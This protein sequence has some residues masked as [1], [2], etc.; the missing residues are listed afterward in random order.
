MNEYRALKGWLLAPHARPLRL[1]ACLPG[2]RLHPKV[3]GWVAAPDTPECRSALEELGYLRRAEE[4]YHWPGPQT[5]MAHQRTTVDFLMRHRRCLVLNDMGTGK[6]LSAIWAMHRLMLAGEIKRALVICPLSTIHFTWG[7]ALFRTLWPEG[8]RYEALTAPAASRLRKLKGSQQID[9]L[10]HGDQ[11]LKAIAKHSIGRYDLVVID[12]VSKYRNATKTWT[13]F[14]QWVS[15]PQ[16]EEMRVWGMTGT[17]TPQRPADS[18]VLSKLIRNKH[19]PKTWYKCRDMLEFKPYRD[20]FRWT[21]RHGWQ[22]HVERMLQPSIRYKLSECV[23]IPETTT[24]VRSVALTEHQRKAYKDMK[25]TLVAEVEGGEI[26]AAN[27]G[28]RLMRLVQICGGAGYI[29]GPDNVVEVDCKP[30][31][32]ECREILDASEGKAIIFV[33]YVGVL[34]LVEKELSKHYSCAVVIG[35]VNANKRSEIFK[36]FQEDSVPRVLL[37]VPQTMSHGLTLTAASTII[38]WSP[39]SSNETYRQACARVDRIG[40]THPCSVVQI[41]SSPVEREMYDS[42]AGRQSN[43]SALLSALT[44][45]V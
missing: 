18:W 16:H 15:M 22:H 11:A 34:R 19:A 32:A 35:A 3:A 7:M 42:I 36:A 31:L 9:L 2:G 40:K 10:N 5:P 25:D 29:D 20:G 43:Q 12:E 38:W 21:P 14:W 33:P 39:V 37:A 13:E 4:E 28:V 30:R 24:Q 26:T 44:E 45:E 1:A 6:T 17:P 8:I 23:D 41:V 27:A